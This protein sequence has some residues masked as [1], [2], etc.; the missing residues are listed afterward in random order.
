MITMSYYLID[1]K[2]IKNNNENI[3]NFPDSL[4]QCGIL[5][6]FE[7]ITKFNERISWENS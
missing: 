2:T 1:I 7:L 5:R 6:N 3:C 4:D